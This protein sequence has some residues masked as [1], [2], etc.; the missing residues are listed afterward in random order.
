MSGIAT[1]QTLQVAAKRNYMAKGFFNVQIKDFE[2]RS[3][4][5]CRCFI[6]NDKAYI[7]TKEAQVFVRITIKKTNKT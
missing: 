1:G 2:D 7:D 5:F 6:L 4:L 3:S